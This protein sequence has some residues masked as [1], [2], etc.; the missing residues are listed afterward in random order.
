MLC[1]IKMVP[2]QTGIVTTH[3]WLAKWFVNWSIIKKPLC[4]IGLQIIISIIALDQNCFVKASS[5]QLRTHKGLFDYRV[6]ICEVS[7]QNYA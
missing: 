6:N 1:C 2:K 4:F 7:Y 3:S 5:A